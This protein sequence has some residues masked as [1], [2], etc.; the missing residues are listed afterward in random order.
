[1]EFLDEI[2]KES[3]EIQYILNQINTLSPYG[4]IYKDKIK[5]FLPG[6]EEALKEELEKVE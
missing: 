1:M 2:T 4:K 6:E 3:L 5:P